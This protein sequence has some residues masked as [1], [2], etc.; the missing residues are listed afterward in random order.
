MTKFQSP[1]RLT[2]RVSGYLLPVIHCELALPVACRGSKPLQKKAWSSRLG[3]VQRADYPLTLK[4]TLELQ[5]PIPEQPKSHC[6]GLLM[7]EVSEVIPKKLG[8]EQQKG[9]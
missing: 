3:V 9:R 4:K 2:V 1:V 6:D 7:A 8:V 5:K